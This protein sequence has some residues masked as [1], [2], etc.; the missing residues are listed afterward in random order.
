[1]NS[2]TQKPRWVVGFPQSFR[3]A[4][5]EMDQLFGK[6]FLPLSEAE[7]AFTNAFAAPVSLW[8]ANDKIHVAVELP[9][10]KREDVDITL[11]NHVL[12]IAAERKAPEAEIHY[13]HQ[14]RRY[15]KVQRV[16]SLPETV[17]PESIAAELK[18]GVLTLEI[19]KRPEV[20]PRKIAIKE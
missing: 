6:I 9:G 3:E 4:Q 15:G 12:R 16:I 1:M 10:V 13:R 20:Q 14:E 2:T 17:D 8:E 19:A 5:R 7:A 18:D 11:E